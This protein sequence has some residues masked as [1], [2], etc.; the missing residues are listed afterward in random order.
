MI[1]SPC[2]TAV[3]EQ[4]RLRAPSAVAAATYH[5]FREWNVPVNYDL[6]GRLAPMVDMFNMEL[7]RLDD[8]LANSRA[9][10]CRYAADAI[11][12]GGSHLMS[13]T[14]HAAPAD[15]VEVYAAA[16]ARRA[17]LI[18]DFGQCF[19]ADIHKAADA[20]GIYID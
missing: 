8:V 2:T 7:M 5:T 14:D 17:A 11:S 20:L 13:P 12:V 1:V 3:G 16:R 19:A 10:Y 15:S 6:R 9:A 18:A 4:F